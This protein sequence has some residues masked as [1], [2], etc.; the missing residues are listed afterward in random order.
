M[1]MK[2]ILI[3]MNVSLIFS[4][5]I[6][7]I[8]NPVKNSK[9]YSFNFSISE[10]NCNF[11][12]VKPDSIA[13][14][15]IMIKNIANNPVKLN[16]I[17]LKTTKDSTL[18]QGF[19]IFYNWDIQTPFAVGEI[20]EI[21]IRFQN[22]K[23]GLFSDSLGFGDSCY[24]KYYALVRACTGLG[25]I[26][27][28]DIDFLSRPIFTKGA[29]EK[30]FTILGTI[31][32]R[33]TYPLYISNKILPSPNNFKVFFLS[34]PEDIGYELNP[35]NKFYFEIKFENETSKECF[36]SL[37][38][39]CH[40]NSINSDSICYINAKSFDDSL[41]VDLNKLEYCLV[42]YLIVMVDFK[43]K[44]SPENTFTVQMSD[45]TGSFKSPKNIY[46][47]TSQ[48]KDTIF[49]KVPDGIIIGTKYRIRLLCSNPPNWSSDNLYDIRISE[50]PPK[51]TITQKG[52]KLTSSNSIGY[53]WFRDGKSIYGAIS[54]LYT[55][56]VDGYYQV[57][58]TEKSCNSDLSDSVYVKVTSV[59]DPQF[60]NSD[61]FLI[62]PNPAKDYITVD[63]SFMPMQESE[64][65]I[66]NIFG[67]RVLIAQTPSSEQRIDVSALPEGIYFVRIGE[68]IGKFVVVR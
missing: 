33:G 53:Q 18:T 6:Y 34:I 5:H 1:K 51:P 2:Y 54:Q 46:S 26:E 48:K 56:I 62:S 37:V 4:C 42:D 13:S 50:K 41:I 67:E 43:K 55:A 66:Y 40:N 52:N 14:H 21:Y 45:A 25:E 27:V 30:G 28:S 68:K 9:Y 44:Y 11:G 60:S 39:R 29:S 23:I 3:L 47:F 15:R 7:A 19:D 8:E 10:K 63:T 32:N 22:N 49:C 12:Y 24:F 61:L 58:V 57:R 38:I 31:K 65:M 35:G 20:R 16:K 36:D 64:I 17:I 59:P